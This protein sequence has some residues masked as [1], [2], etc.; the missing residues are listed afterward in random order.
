MLANL[1][2]RFTSPD[3][4]TQRPIVVRNGRVHGW[5]ASRG[6]KESSHGVWVT[7]DARWLGLT[8][9]AGDDKTACHV[10]R[11]PKTGRPSSVPKS[12]EVKPFRTKEEIRQYGETSWWPAV[13][14]HFSED[15]A[16]TALIGDDK[17]CRWVFCSPGNW[18]F[19][20]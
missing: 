11:F 2:N 17:N 9:P 18:R 7:S 16:C 19:V 20:R 6:L 4:S 14:V 1:F 15:G 13:D 8:W 3:I 5:M 10:I 12:V